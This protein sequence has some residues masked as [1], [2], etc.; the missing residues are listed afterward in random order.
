MSPKKIMSPLWESIDKLHML[1]PGSHMHQSEYNKALEY[2]VEAKMLAEEYEK[3][4]LRKAFE[5]EGDFE[6]W[7][8]NV[9]CNE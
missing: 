1:L 3:E 6:E 2:I 7:F 5:A 9:Y 4:E 8:N